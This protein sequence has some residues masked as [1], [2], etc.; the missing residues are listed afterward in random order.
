MAGE[1]FRPP[2]L[3]KKEWALLNSVLDMELR[4]SDNYIDKE[5]K[6]LYKERNGTQV[7]AIYGIGDGTEATVLYAVG[8]A[9]AS[10]AI[11]ALRKESESFAKS[12][13]GKPAE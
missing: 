2:Q 4:L 12:N 3:S 6:W 8:G 10:R 7:F 5:T 1:K 9:E 13:G 11:K